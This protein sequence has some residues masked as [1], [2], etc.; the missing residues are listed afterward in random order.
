MAGEALTLV[1][2]PVMVHDTTT[3][4][5]GRQ[6]GRWIYAADLVSLHDDGS[7]TV[8]NYRTVLDTRGP[9]LSGS[10]P[11]PMRVKWSRI[12][13]RD[14]TSGPGPG[15]PLDLGS[16]VGKRVFV[17]DAVRDGKNVG[18]FHYVGDLVSVS[19]PTGVVVLRNAFV[20]LNSSVWL[21]QIHEVGKSYPGEIGLPWSTIEPS[22]F[23]SEKPVPMGG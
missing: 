3:W 17:R 16:L 12:E 6:K 10:V 11:G 22:P 21:G 4:Q 5:N 18:F 15:T 2:R 23:T 20:V 13:K 14:E 19:E 7:A 9:G 1:G 8:K